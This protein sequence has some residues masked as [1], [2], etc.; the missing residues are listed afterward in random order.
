MMLERGTEQSPHTQEFL[1]CE[2][3]RTL[4]YGY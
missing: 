1:Q 2:E 4:A 3:Q